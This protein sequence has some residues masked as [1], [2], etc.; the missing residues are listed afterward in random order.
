MKNIVSNL[1]STLKEQ[2]ELWFFIFATI[3]FVAMYF[4]SFTDESILV[5]PG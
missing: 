1:R 2:P 4:W 3:V 5:F